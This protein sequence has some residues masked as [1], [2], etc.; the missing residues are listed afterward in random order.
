MIAKNK[1]SHGVRMGTG[2]LRSLGIDPQFME[3]AAILIGASGAWNSLKV[4]NS[5]LNKVKAAEAKYSL[6]LDFPW[7]SVELVHFTLACASDGLKATTVR[8]YIS[9]V[10]KAHALNNIPWNLDTTLSNAIVR[11]LENTTDPTRKRIAITPRMLISFKEKIFESRKTWPRHDRRALWALIAWLWSGSFRCSE[12]LA[13][14]LTGYIGEQTFTWQNMKENAG[15][16]DGS[17]MRWFTVTLVK[18]KEHRAGKAGVNIELFNIVA[19]WNPVEAMDLFR[20]ANIHGEKPGLPVFRWA[21]GVNITGSFLNKFIKN[22]GIALDEYP[23]GVY[24]GT[25]SFRAGI[26][27][28]MGAMGCE[29]SLIKSIGRWGGDSWLRYAKS[30][31]SIRKSDQMNIQ[32]RAAGEFRNWTPIPVLVE[33]FEDDAEI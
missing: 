16:I 8:N 29:E 11:G 4:H 24:L 31:R 1:Y 7:S 27:S 10:K 3:K 14:T 15:K 5:A 17:M 25:H 12:L 32:A 22:C 21:S 2:A 30:G 28:L 19:P 26:V 23:D 9:Q 6:T 33:E 13:P 20:K 18:P